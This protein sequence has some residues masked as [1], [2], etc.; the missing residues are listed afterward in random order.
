MASSDFWRERA[1][2]FDLVPDYGT[3]RADGQYTVGSG[4][5]WT[6]QVAGGAL[7]EFIRSTFETLARRAAMELPDVAAGT[8]LLV[9]WLEAIR[10]EGINFRQS[11]GPEYV[12]GTIEQVCKASVILCRKVESEALQAEFAEKQRANPKN[13]SE[14]HQ[15]IEAA[16][17]FK[18][19]RNAPAKRIS[20]ELARKTIA[21]IYGISPEQVTPQIINFE[22][23]R[24]LP[25]YHHIELNPSTRK[26]ES[27][28]PDTKP[29]D[30][31][32]PKPAPGT[33]PTE[34]IAA[35]IQR[36][37]EECRWT[38]EKLAE[39][40]GMSTSAVAR[41]LSGKMPYARNISAYERAFSKQLKTN[42]VIKKM[43]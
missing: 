38:I 22:I 2:E 4:A 28:A 35:Q 25:F 13:W 9:A 17:S 30:Q 1:T 39:V 8:D 43:P 37:R 31:A 23:A 32:E 10:K 19:V 3:L 11:A 5:A 27:P 14:F 26:Q 21:Q 29:G 36:L 7:N 40:T 18:D 15:M 24:L 33:P 16:E 41:H 20:E 6:W 34:T 42:I 12:I